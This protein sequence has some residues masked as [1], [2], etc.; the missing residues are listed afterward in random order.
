MTDTSCEVLECSPNLVQSTMSLFAS[1]NKIYRRSNLQFG[2][3]CQPLS[4]NN[5]PV[6]NFGTN[7]IR[8]K[9]CRAYINPYAEIMN[10]GKEWKCNLCHHISDLPS[11]YSCFDHKMNDF[12]NEMK[13]CAFDIS[14]PSDYSIRPPQTP[15]YTFV[16]N[17]CSSMI[18]CGLLSSI[19]ETISSSLNHL[20]EN[21]TC[22]ISFITYHDKIHFYEFDK[23]W[24][25]PK[26]YVMNDVCDVCL[27]IP[28]ERLIVNV[29]SMYD[30][31]YH[32][33]N[34]LPSMFVNCECIENALGTAIQCAS[35]VL[36][37]MGG[38]IICFS[39][40]LPTIGLGKLVN[41]MNVNQDTLFTDEQ[42][43]AKNFHIL[44][45][46]DNNYFMDMAI[47]LT[48]YH[49]NV[50]LFQ[51]CDYNLFC[52]LSTIKAICRCGGGQLYYYENNGSSLIQMQ[53]AISNDLY[54]NITR[55]QAWEAVMRVRVSKGITIKH[56]YG[57]YYRRSADL[58]VLP[59]VD[60]DKT[61]AV[62]FAHMTNDSSIDNHPL[63][64]SPFIYVQCALL[65]TN[66]LSQR[67][68][69]VMTVRYA[70]S[71]S[72]EQLFSS[73]NLS[74]M[75]A[76]IAK[77]S[78]FK[79]LSKDMPTARMFI[80]DSCVQSVSAIM[81]ESNKWS[82]MNETEYPSSIAF[83][84]LITLGLLKC[85]AFADIRD[86]HTFLSVDE[87][88]FL[89][90]SILHMSVTSL[91]LLLRPSLMTL[92]V[93]MI[94]NSDEIGEWKD[95]DTQTEV[96]LPNECALTQHSMQDTDIHLLDN[97]QYIYIRIGSHM[98]DIHPEQ[99]PF[100]LQSNLSANTAKD[101]VFAQFH[102]KLW[103]IIRYI[104][105]INYR[106]QAL[107]MVI[108]N[109]E[110]DKIFT[111]LYLVRDRTDSVMNYSEF[112]SFLR[113]SQKSNKIAN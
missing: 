34:D 49:I 27:P 40:G 24:N 38:K 33:L 92:N 45:K 17:V 62:V 22:N 11:N 111:T 81:K 76:L 1:N 35:L 100:L 13:Y 8:C 104:R 51:I 99:Y 97:G 10:K 85:G 58:L 101:H 44:L 88:T 60:Q 5:L 80:Q 86:V 7:V 102:R 69:R 50:D 55:V 68:I 105:S 84:P 20:K 36:R 65:Y 29:H 59:T 66:S 9:V 14:A 21:K 106:F 56:Y 83:W 75:T 107:R 103:N 28:N 26:M 93:N 43:Y 54:K 31:I 42:S 53:N 61:F 82:F 32:F 30:Q 94:T 78:V 2:I 74:A 90:T 15:C 72:I 63:F 37:S 25:K 64:N 73:V 47:Q 18:S 19:C 96:Y 16:L 98:K 95:D 91:D 70:C 57:C 48:K 79:M 113:E 109:T 71:S 110:S 87:R 52:D 108:Q 46:R 3:I 112:L 77:Q 67:R 23:R 4:E 12:R 39:Y 89:L 6:I 41:R